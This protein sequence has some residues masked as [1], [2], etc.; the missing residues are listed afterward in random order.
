MF[1]PQNIVSWSVLCS[2]A[3]LMFFWWSQEFLHGSILGP[4]LFLV[5]VNDI[6]STTIPSLFLFADDS[7]CFSSIK[8][9]EDC[10]LFQNDLDTLTQ[11]SQYWKLKFD[12][13]KCV[14]VKF[15]SLNP[16]SA[17]SINGSPIT[18]T[19]EHKDV[20]IMVTSNLSFAIASHINHI[21]SKA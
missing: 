5:Y 12:V 10:S 14:Y 6:F 9:S 21:L 8:C 3:F 15:G 18:G 4:L 1:C 16:D 19:T 13:P 7:Q 17:Y 11:W 2:L 20:G